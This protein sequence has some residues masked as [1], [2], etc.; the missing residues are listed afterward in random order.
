MLAII[1]GHTDGPKIPITYVR[2]G[3]KVV[4]EKAQDL[5]QKLNSGEEV[6]PKLTKLISG[7]GYRKFSFRVLLSAEE[8]GVENG[9]K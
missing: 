4:V 3:K 2:G 7:C 9:Q 6:S 5:V 1:M 8:L